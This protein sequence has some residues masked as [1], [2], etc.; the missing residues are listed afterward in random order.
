MLLRHLS[1]FVTLAEEKHFKKAAE[2]CNI[3]QPT[4]SA[5]I[6]KLEEDLGVT[7]IVRGHRYL[8]L[9][10][11]GDKAL[12][13]GRQILTDYDSLRDEL[14]GTHKGLAGTL[15][16]GVIPA[17]MPSIAFLTERFSERFPDV[18]VDIRSV[19]SRAIQ[20]GIDDFAFDGGLTYLDNE[21]LENV[22]RF[23]LYRERYVFVCQ[24]DHP[25][26]DREA[27]T[28]A[29]AVREPLCLLSNDMQNRRILDGIAESAGLKIAPPIVSDSFLAVCA[30]L[31]NGMWCG[32]VPHTFFYIFGGASGL[33]PINLVE[34]TADHAIGLVLKA[35]LPRS[36]MVSA[37]VAA[38]RGADFEARFK[39]AMDS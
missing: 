17:A 20:R 5:A 27:V 3:T 24:P 15:R 16:L 29:E 35:R 12:A 25:L 6:R 26:A 10:P 34:P 13:W 8:G 36:P 1:F 33:V 31:R 9:T 28:W 19:T 2:A 23:Q 14:H 18:Q 11:E 7:L 39:Q 30:H 21:P 38:L 4:L 22:D 37:L 32:I